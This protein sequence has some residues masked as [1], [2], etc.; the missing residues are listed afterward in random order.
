MNKVCRYETW[1]ALRPTLIQCFSLM[2][3]LTLIAQGQQLP[4]SK[5]DSTRW[6]VYSWRGLPDGYDYE[7]IDYDG[8][9][10]VVKNKDTVITL[11]SESDAIPG[12]TEL[13]EDLD[14]FGGTLPS[15][16]GAGPGVLRLLKKHS[17]GVQQVGPRKVVFAYYHNDQIRFYSA[18]PGHLQEI[19]SVPKTIDIGGT[20]RDP[21]WGFRKWQYLEIG[22]RPVI[23]AHWYRDRPEE[24]MLLVLDQGQPQELVAVGDTVQSAKLALL[25]SIM[26][27]SIGHSFMYDS[28]SKKCLIGGRFTLI[29]R[30]TGSEES[31]TGFLLV[32]KQKIIPLL[33]RDQVIRNVDGSHVA[34]P[35]YP[36]SPYYHRFDRLDGTNWRIDFKRNAIVAHVPFKTDKWY[37]AFVIGSEAGLQTICSWKEGDTLP[38][39][40]GGRIECFYKEMELPEIYHNTIH[41][42]TDPEYSLQFWWPTRVFSYYVKPDSQEVISYVKIEDSE[43][44]IEEGIFS[45]RRDKIT[46]LVAQNDPAPGTQGVS[47][48]TPGVFSSFWGFDEDET[49]NRLLFKAEVRFGAFA[50]APTAQGLFL[51]SNGR[52]TKIAMVSEIIPCRS[53]AG[54]IE[55]IRLTAIRGFALLPNGMIKFRGEFKDGAD[56]FFALQH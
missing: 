36:N 37:H 50:L 5:I 13:F 46:K 7:M 40:N 1:T 49:N 26:P 29:D 12:S 35:L 22:G 10:I 38:G 24:S 8:P 55:N 45:C 39:T 53:R 28:D 17:F 3:V 25:R 56:L 44:G 4:S 9:Q 16:G 27:V 21:G 11:V 2:I 19:M 18:I 14:S 43:T 30:Q 41:T 54:Q 51:L 32:Y 23:V 20:E 15:G 52:I 31:V 33:L 48:G 34:D 42:A 6:Q 47:P